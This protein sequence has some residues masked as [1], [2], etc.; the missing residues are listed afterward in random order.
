MS[1]YRKRTALLVLLLICTLFASGCGRRLV[2]TRGYKEDELFRVGN[3]QCR[4]P[5]YNVFLLNLQKQCERTFGH[6]V[7]E[8]PKGAEL[9]E[10]VFQ[11][12]LSEVSRLKVM[13]LLAVQDNIMLTDAEEN[14][15]DEAEM[16]YYESISE[17][18]RE[19]LGI[20]EEALRVLFV[21]YALAQKVYNSAG[22][23]FEERYDSFCTTLDYDLNEPLWNTVKLAE[24]EDLADTP[25]FTDVYT[26]YFGSASLGAQEP[27]EE[28]EEEAETTVK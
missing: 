27:E 5:E 9:K 16:E 3:T 2:M 12:A 28:P 26:K 10:A 24:I 6:D 8:G 7:W 22:T 25:G 1:K 23:S 20:S 13:L 15:A 17:A 21:Q 14:V 18:E 19:Y 11:R 4:L